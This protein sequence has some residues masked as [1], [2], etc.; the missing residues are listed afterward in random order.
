[1]KRITLPRLELLSAL[2]ATRL[3]RYFCQATECDISKATLWNDSAIVLAWIRGDPN[4][5]KTFVCNRVTEI[6]EYTAPSQWRHCSG[7]ENPAYIVS[8]GLHAQDLSTSNTWCTGPVWLRD[9]PSDWPRDIH[10]DR[11]SIPEKRATPLQ[12]LT[13]STRAPSSK[14]TNSAPTPNSCKLWLGYLVFWETSGQQR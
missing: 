11:A 14:A 7:S 10:N 5:Y 2:V 3:L 13:V 1:M 4:R 8:R 12:A 9:A 6:L